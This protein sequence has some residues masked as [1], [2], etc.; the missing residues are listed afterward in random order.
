MEDRR[1]GWALGGYKHT[2]EAKRKMGQKH[3]GEKHYN[4]QGGKSFEPYGVEFNEEKKERIRNKFNRRCFECGVSE[5]ESRYKLSIHHID[6]NKR[7]NSEDNLIPLCVNCHSQ[8]GFKRK[9]WE[10][11]FKNKLGLKNTLQRP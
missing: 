6:Y 7:N 4:W 5:D 9:D 2:E 3:K 11:Y 1:V 10:N 8:T